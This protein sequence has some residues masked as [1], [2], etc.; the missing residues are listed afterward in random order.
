[1]FLTHWIAII[2]SQTCPIALRCPGNGR[3]ATADKKEKRRQGEGR[4]PLLRVKTGALSSTKSE[5]AHDLLEP[6][7]PYFVSALFSQASDSRLI[8]YMFLKRKEPTEIGRPEDRLK[9]SGHARRQNNEYPGPKATQQ[10]TAL[11]R[12]LYT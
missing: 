2:A 11:R 6:P 12:S 5:L 1:M 3:S 4:T 7:T 9:R 10:A 8:C